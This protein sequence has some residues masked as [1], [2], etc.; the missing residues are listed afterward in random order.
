[1]KLQTNNTIAMLLLLPLLE[2][3]MSLYSFESL[4]S[5]LSFQ[6]EGVPLAF[7]IGKGLW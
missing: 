3:M 5:V 6:P 4:C 2:I 7:L 1:M